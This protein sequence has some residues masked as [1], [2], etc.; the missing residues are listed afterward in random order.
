[1]TRYSELTRKVYS[2]L[3]AALLCKVEGPHDMAAMWQSKADE[4]VSFRDS[5]PIKEAY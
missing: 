2:L 1:M 4:L 3:G 5:L